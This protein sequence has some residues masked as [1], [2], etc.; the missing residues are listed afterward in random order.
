MRV[1]PFL[2]FV[3]LLAGC[4]QASNTDSA[5]LASAAKAR[6][7]G[8]GAAEA[9]APQAGGART[10][11]VETP[12]APRLVARNA[13]LTLRV[14]SVESAERQIGRASRSVGGLVEASQGTD[15][16]GPTPGMSITLRVPESRF[17]E[18]LRLLE[19]FGTRLGKTISSED[20]TAQAVDLDAR[21]RSLRVQEEAYRAILAAARRIPDVLA[22]QEKLTGVRTEIERIVAGR[23]DLGDQAERSKIVVTLS[24]ALTPMAAPPEPDWLVQ[25]WGDATGTL[26]SCGRGL[27]S[28]GLWALAMLPIWLPV[29]LVGVFLARRG[30][31]TRA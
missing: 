21:A 2:L 16:A 31:T 13:E 25:T 23:R 1:A 24:Q 27:A 9:M 6:R 22:I 29:V 15:L 11:S 30:A 17:D 7:S 19:G 26:R 4:G 10:A 28:L 14:K 5:T 8:V 18:A 20:V 3:V 12:A